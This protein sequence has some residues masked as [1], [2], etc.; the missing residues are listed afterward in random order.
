MVV[1]SSLAYFITHVVT[2]VSFP[3]KFC[4]FSEQ[5]NEKIL[6]FIFFHCI[7]NRLYYFLEK[8]HQITHTHIHTHIVFDKNFLIIT[9][10]VMKKYQT[11]ISKRTVKSKEGN[12][13]PY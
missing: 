7:F 5:K 13:G 2:A 4:L 10:L 11:Q 3:Q 9:I 1:C 12:K 8:I 6:D